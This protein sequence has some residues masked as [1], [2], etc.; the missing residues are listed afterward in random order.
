M[1]LCSPLCLHSIS[2]SAR[3]FFFS[4]PLIQPQC[5]LLL[6]R[7]RELSWKW[8]QRFFDS[9]FDILFI[10]VNL[11]FVSISTRHG[12]TKH[13]LQHLGDATNLWHLLHTMER[14]F[15]HHRWWS[16]YASEQPKRIHKTPHKNSHSP[17][18]CFHLPIKWIIYVNICFYHSIF[19][20]QCVQNMNTKMSTRL[21]FGS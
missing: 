1:S 21:Y 9:D 17:W 3:I 19:I 14:K 8:K 7:S 4:F 15:L 12:Q 18:N 11:L 16:P 10:D 6:L 20:A 5:L 2:R 13:A